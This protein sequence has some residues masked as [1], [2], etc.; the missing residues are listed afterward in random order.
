MIAKHWIWLTVVSALLIWAPGA[1]ANPGVQSYE[2]PAA[3]PGV[4]ETPPSV[5][6]EIAFHKVHHR[7]GAPWYAAHFES[8]AI[9]IYCP[10]GTITSA[11]T[12]NDLAVPSFDALS[13]DNQK[14]D[15]RK[16]RFAFTDSDE[17]ESAQVQLTGHVGRKGNAT[18]TVRITT[19][20]IVVDSR[21]HGNPDG[22]TC[23][24]GTVSWTAHPVKAFSP[25]V[26]PPCALQGTCRRVG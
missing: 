19:A 13:G 6:L 12:A 21:G 17:W 16:G 10:N 22:N 14:T 7:R 18:G 11:G 2:G 26:V 5:R 3:G 20:E 8:R 1:S 24:S 4:Q 9:P 15:L 25:P 23:D